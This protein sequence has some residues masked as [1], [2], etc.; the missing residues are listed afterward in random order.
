M[1]KATPPEATPAQVQAALLAL[2]IDTPYY[3]ARIDREA[4]CVVIT[5]YGGAARRWP[6]APAAAQ[7]KA[8]PRERSPRPQT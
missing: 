6:L 1:P 4:G 3:T 8:L 7:R 2:H 5:L